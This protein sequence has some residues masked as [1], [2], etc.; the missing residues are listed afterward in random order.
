MP[1]APPGEIDRIIGKRIR[2]RRKALGVT[3]A[4]LGMAVGV[5][6]QQ[7]QKYET[8]QNHVTASRLHDIAH[9]LQMPVEWFFET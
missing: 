3:M 6:F 8:G 4:A 7:I 1:K 9:Q 5:E 2:Q